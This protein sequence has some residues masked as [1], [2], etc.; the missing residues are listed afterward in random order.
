[1]DFPIRVDDGGLAGNLAK[2]IAELD[3]P[4]FG[5]KTAEAF[6]ETALPGAPRRTGRLA[7]SIQVVGAAVEI[8][9]VYGGPIVGGWWK[10]HIQ[11]HP[12]IMQLA[13]DEQ[14]WADVMEQREVQPILDQID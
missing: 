14:H 11:P 1:M 12:W 7:G 3:S 5:S 13:R 8:G 6:R 4:L 2:A 9:V 10:H